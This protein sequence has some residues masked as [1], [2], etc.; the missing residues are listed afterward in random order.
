MLVVGPPRSGK[1]S[2]LVIP[3]IVSANGPV[4]STSTKSDVMAITATARSVVGRCR[5]FDPGGKTT[6]A[7]GVETMAWS[8]VDGCDRWDRALAMARAMVGAARPAVGLSDA[9]HWKERAQAI[10]AALLH[11]AA[12][13][14]WSMIDLVGW[15]NRRQAETAQ[16]V[17][18]AHRHQHGAQLAH[19]LLTGIV[20]GEPRELSGIWSTA[21]G[22]LAAYRFESVLA[23]TLTDGGYRDTRDRGVG[24]NKASGRGVRS[25]FCADEFVRSGG[26]IYICADAQTQAVTAPLVAGLLEQVRHAAYLRWAEEVGPAGGGGSRARANPAPVLLALDEVANIAPLADLPA[27]VSEGGSQGLSTLACLQDLSQARVRWGQ[28]ADGFFS[29]FGAKVVLP[30]V[31]DVRTLEA[32]SRLVGDENVTIRSRSLSSGPRWPGRLA[33]RLMGQYPERPRDSVTYSSRRQPRL[34]PDVV[35]RGRPGSA[36]VLEGPG[37]ASWVTLSPWYGHEPW[38]SLAGPESNQRGRDRTPHHGHDRDSGIPAARGISGT[39]TGPAS[40]PDRGLG[41]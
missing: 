36:L 6:P 3:N 5:L 14:S 41:L 16:G 19:D 7:P 23:A 17:L 31:G 32:L 28:A 26:T 39:A 10:M 38:L 22:V 13:D 4:V 15:V 11:A 21:S 2:S 30:G 25:S 20:S 1:T 8:P 29:L 9:E 34:P 40:P 18:V 33:T 27:M 24:G 37:L 12:L 35:A